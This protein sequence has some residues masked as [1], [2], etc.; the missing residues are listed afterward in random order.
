MK[1]APIKILIMILFTGL[2]CILGELIISRQLD[3]LQEKHQDIMEISVKNR[4]Y[5]A[6]IKT[7]LYEHQALLSNYAL[8]DSQE[9]KYV[10]RSQETTL[11][12]QLTQEIIDFSYRMKIG[13]REVIYHRVYSD[14]S[15][16]KENTVLYLEFIENDEYDMAMYYNNNVLKGY[17]E[18][19]NS[20]LDDLDRLTAEEIH[21]AE[22]DMAKAVENSMFLRIAIIGIAVVFLVICICICVRITSDLDNYKEGLEKEL[23]ETVLQQHNENMIMLQDG[24]IISM[25]NLIESRNGE[26]GEHVKRTST[27]VEMIA[28]E[29]AKQGYYTDILCEEYIE[30]LK[31]VAPLHDVGKIA[32]PD[33]ILMKPGKLTPEEFEQIKLHASKGG[34]II[35][36]FFEHLE[37]KEYVQMAIDVS[38]YHHEKWNGEGY[39]KGLKE[40]EIP[41]SARIM[42]IAD[43]FDALISKR[44]YKEAY[45]IDAAFKIMEESSGS[46]FDPTLIK[47]FLSMRTT[48]EAYI[49]YENE[50]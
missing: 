36:E 39:M 32:V 14:Y 31:K 22:Q 41:L 7:K 21:R 2:I 43:V 10:Y 20:K 50:C 11:R 37:D 16:Y 29:T 23:V 24:I 47:V 5:M 3:H 12:E 1:K 38:S 9:F 6:T 18:D 42:A 49:K 28:R 40:E 8:A 45:P 13:Q 33:Q 34:E 25:A 44:C 4:E 19:I 17:L 46:H 30:R 35:R 26:T 15:G 27:Y 48:I